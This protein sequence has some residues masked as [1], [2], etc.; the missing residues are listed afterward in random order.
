MEKIYDDDFSLEKNL[1]SK[2]DGKTDR[3]IELDIYDGDEDF[4][5][6][7]K[8]LIDYICKGRDIFEDMREEIE[9][10]RTYTNPET[11]HKVENRLKLV[12]EIC[13]RIDKLWTIK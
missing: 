6:L 13:E 1:L 11:R 4:M 5:N 9:N 12:E 8:E 7:D 10:S 3:E 2:L